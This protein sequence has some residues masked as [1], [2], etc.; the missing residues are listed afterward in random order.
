M[1][2]DDLRNG[3]L[4]LICPW[5]VHLGGELDRF[6]EDGDGGLEGEGGERQVGGYRGQVTYQPATIS[7]TDE[8]KSEVGI[9]TGK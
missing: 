4:L 3:L 9:D 2:T 7:T 8:I 1:Y 5:I 6:W